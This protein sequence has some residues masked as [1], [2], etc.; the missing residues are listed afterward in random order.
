MAAEFC[1]Q[2]RTSRTGAFRYCRSCGFDYDAGEVLTR[3]AAASDTAPGRA[4]SFSERYRRPAGVQPAEPP[5]QPT[6]AVPS[7]LGQQAA[8]TPALL[9]GAA[10]IAS[11]AFM[12][13]LA[14]L[15]LGYAN[16]SPELG[17]L[18]LWNGLTAAI[19]LYFGARLLVRPAGVLTGSVIWGV[20]T[21]AWNGYQIA[22]GA[23]HEAYLGATVTAGMATV[24]SFVARS[25]MRS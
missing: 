8:N 25:Q 9:A 12:G 22:Q 2:C 6:L 21:V 7:A 18:A 19:T 17:S 10:W 24:L 1:P 3:P 20:L 4:Q 5:A 11:A 16:V 23:T 15:Q 14:L 13:Y